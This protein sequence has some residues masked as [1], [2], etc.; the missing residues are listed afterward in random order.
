M[1]K[2]FDKKDPTEPFDI[3]EQLAAIQRIQDENPPDPTLVGESLDAAEALGR[4]I[5]NFTKAVAYS[6]PV[7]SPF[8]AYES[9]ENMTPT[10]SGLL[11][12]SEKAAPYIPGWFKYAAVVFP[13]AAP[14]AA[15]KDLGESAEY[16][17]QHPLARAVYQGVEG[18][19]EWIG[20]GKAIGAAEG[21]GEKI[22]EFSPALRGAL[23]AAA[24]FVTGSKGGAEESIDSLVASSEPASAETIGNVA[25]R[26]AIKK[27]TKR[28]IV[29]S[30][31]GGAVGAAYGVPTHSIMQGAA[32]GALIGAI[33]GAYSPETKILIAENIGDLT[34][35]ADK[36]SLRALKLVSSALRDQYGLKP[37]EAEN[38]IGR[39]LTNNAT[40][41]ERFAIVQALKV[42]PEVG[43]T[44]LGKRLIW[45]VRKVPTPEIVPT[46][47][48]SPIR[49]DYE[50]R[51]R[52]PHS[53]TL[54]SPDQ[55]ERYGRL[56]ET[57]D[58]F[59]HK[60]SGP[61]DA[62]D[63]LRLIKPPQ[64]TPYPVPDEETVKD[65]LETIKSG[66]G[67]TDTVSRVFGGRRGIVQQEWKEEPPPPPR[68]PTTVEA[69]TPEA[70]ARMRAT[71]AGPSGQHGVMVG[72]RR[73]LPAPPERPL[74]G[75]ASSSPPPEPP[76]EPGYPKLPENQL[77]HYSAV[78]P[79]AEARLR[80]TTE[81]PPERQGVMVGA[82]RLLPPPSSQPTDTPE[83]LMPFVP[84]GEPPEVQLFVGTPTEAGTP[85]AAPGGVEFVI[86]PTANPATDIPKAPQLVMP[87]R[88]TTA[89]KAVFE[90]IKQPYSDASETFF[91][92]NSKHVVEMAVRGIVQ[93]KDINDANVARTIAGVLQD[94]ALE[95]EETAKKGIRLVKPETKKYSPEEK[96]WAT[97]ATVDEIKTTDPK[98][99]QLLE[100]RDKFI[101]R[102][103]ELRGEKP[104]LPVNEL[105]REV[106][107]GDIIRVQPHDEGTVLLT[108]KKGN[109]AIARSSDIPPQKVVKP[110]VGPDV[111][112]NPESL[113]Q[114]EVMAEKV[115]IDELI[116]EDAAASP[117]DVEEL[118]KALNAPLDR[119]QS[120]ED[121]L[122]SIKKMR[123]EKI[124]RSQRGAITF[125]R[126][127]TL[128]DPSKNV[129]A[130]FLEP[131]GIKVYKTSWGETV[132]DING[133]LR[134][135]PNERDAFQ[136]V[137][138]KI[139]LS[140]MAAEQ[141]QVMR[142]GKTTIP[143]AVQAAA[144]DAKEAPP[145]TPEA[146]KGLSKRVDL[147]HKLS[148]A[149]S[150]VP[151][152]RT[153]KYSLRWELSRGK[154]ALAAMGGPGRELAAGLDLFSSGRE[155]LDA[156]DLGVLKKVIPQLKKMGATVRNI[157]TKTA[158]PEAIKLY[159]EQ[160]LPILDRQFKDAQLLGLAGDPIVDKVYVPHS[161]DVRP[162]EIPA[163]LV[164]KMRAAGVAENAEQAAN[165]LNDPDRFLG[166]VEGAADTTKASYLKRLEVL[167]WLRENSASLAASLEK[168]RKGAEGYSDDLESIYR[169]VMARNRRIM[170]AAVFGPN[171]ER[172]DAAFK[173]LT[174]SFPRDLVERAMLTFNDAR[175]KLYVRNPNW[176]VG[177]MDAQR[178][179]LSLSGIKHTYQA[180]LVIARFGY[181]RAVQGLLRT[182]LR[183]LESYNYLKE[184]GA[185]ADLTR[186]SLTE[187]D[188]WA[189]DPQSLFLK[190]AKAVGDVGSLSFHLM[191]STVRTFAANVARNVFKK[192]LQRALAGDAD[193]LALFSAT[194]KKKVTPELLR[195][196]PPDVL[197][198]AFVQE[199]A[200]WAG[201]V[202]RPQEI[203]SIARHT[204][205]VKLGLQFYSYMWQM[206]GNIMD[207]I[208]NPNFSRMRRAKALFGLLTA[209]PVLS[210]L[211]A[212]F[213]HRIGADT[214][215]SLEML[216][217][218]DRANK[219][220]QAG[221]ILYTLLQSAI[222]SHALSILG[223]A[224]QAINLG[225]EDL[226]GR[227]FELS[228]ATVRSVGKLGMGITRFGFYK[229]YGRT[230]DWQ[231]AINDMASAFGALPTAI[232]R[233]ETGKRQL[234][235]PQRQIIRDTLSPRD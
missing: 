112:E 57:G 29:K 193:A 129:L 100:L 4:G 104:P 149:E 182:M 122:Q 45:M 139:T 210:V 174:M 74:L 225:S 89:Q 95:G 66:K 103:F 108:D 113:K 52:T 232:G 148:F 88:L 110:V 3:Q 119:H 128:M 198:D 189:G 62:L 154:A 192:T 27:L 2:A 235:I 54:S 141:E 123:Q 161:F 70:E 44:E 111:W 6:T 125:S 98:K 23:D 156:N 120:F 10:A 124:N 164:E 214:I 169:V 32:T 105:L 78:T 24:N 13:P 188:L 134:K 152:R 204:S 201:M 79:E 133:E 203:P 51:D 107:T 121:F 109:T 144:A 183:P 47:E 143:K 218:W 37:E 199:T 56:A 94:E 158:Q 229:K 84:E 64:P 126:K 127:L 160:V 20:L 177:L 191:M 15:I 146:Q 234:R 83:G 206:T 11:S 208:T 194:L 197:Q 102:A 170:E 38:L 5:W 93:P 219:H 228:P 166:M 72:P 14:L 135:F 187:G 176:M 28:L 115:P 80:A 1:P 172:A 131:L 43:Q 40:D 217:A 165:M 49:V 212:Q 178:L 116:K 215:D 16:I 186:Y 33:T 202:F 9:P 50:D 233:H 91:S 138:G 17:R 224:I 155:A 59:I 163:N 85:V 97:L 90:R 31:V 53:V 211:V 162:E 46:E 142:E 175:G 82:R 231:S 184:V 19:G 205:L 226:M 39:A 153:I 118:N 130:S 171:L 42:Y 114:L 41:A 221:P 157:E 63:R 75:P 61:Q 230:A 209:M 136:F 87:K 76:P 35:L 200:N 179:A 137:H 180:A 167:K 68:G 223:D 26:E 117:E 222:Y 150:A 195:S 8:R 147:Y 55:F 86:P 69:V 12:L 73:L 71:T 34:T 101:N 77:L 185:A 96:F 81:A 190:G 21:V 60:V 65:L 106:G 173:Q 22:L 7:V 99:L 132:L 58:I 140:R 92:R 36:N 213:H 168:A 196:I 207:E 159:E 151:P 48:G 181:T 25:K 30:A 220:P 145:A 216:D 67:F 18:W 227:T